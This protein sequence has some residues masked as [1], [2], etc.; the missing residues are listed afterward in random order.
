MLNNKNKGLQLGQSLALLA[1][2]LIAAQMGYT[3]YQ[4][5]PFCLNDGCRVVERL[6]RVSPLVFNLAGFFFFQAVDWGLRSSRYELRQLPQFVKTLLLAGLAVEGVLLEVEPEA[7]G[8]RDY[9]DR[10]G[11]Q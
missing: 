8:A 5:N 11:R 3:L 10:S 6:T 4:G 1:S 7:G 2:L 9:R